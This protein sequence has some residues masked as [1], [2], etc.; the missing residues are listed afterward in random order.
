MKDF[1]SHLKTTQEHLKRNVSLFFLDSKLRNHCYYLALIHG[2][3]QH[4]QNT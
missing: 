3:S 4:G 2:F 1:V